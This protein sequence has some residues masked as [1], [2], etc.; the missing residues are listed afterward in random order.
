[1]LLGAGNDGVASGFDVGVDHVRKAG[2][3]TET[4]HE[5]SVSE[6]VS[7]RLV[8]ILGFGGCILFGVA[9]QDSAKG[10]HAEARRGR[11]RRVGE[12]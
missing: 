9:R 8:W 5:M 1:M 4:A 6:R 12:R 11:R 2:S 3:E 10:C 7:R